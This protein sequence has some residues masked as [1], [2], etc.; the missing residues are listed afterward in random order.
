M[1]ILFMILFGLGLSMIINSVSE[2]NDI[3]SALYFILGIIQYVAS[4]VLIVIF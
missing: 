2:E 4:I 1:A 3:K